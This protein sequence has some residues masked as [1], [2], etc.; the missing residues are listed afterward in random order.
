MPSSSANRNR[1]LEIGGS[2]SPLVY[3]LLGQLMC[4]K[5]RYK[6]MTSEH[7]RSKPSFS[8]KQ[9]APQLI[10]QKKRTFTLYHHHITICLFTFAHPIH[11]C[12]VFTLSLLL[13]LFSYTSDL[14]SKFIHFVQFECK[15]KEQR[16]TKTRSSGR[17]KH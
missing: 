13:I 12:H 5:Y 17:L 8:L 4:N 9:G 2:L 10:T 11:L 16:I 7:E 1:Q 3:R 6:L 14:P 15:I